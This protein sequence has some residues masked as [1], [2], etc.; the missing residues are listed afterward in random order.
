[1]SKVRSV[2][3]CAHSYNSCNVEGTS[4]TTVINF[5]SV[6]DDFGELSNF[7]AYPIVIGGK[8]FPT[9]EHY[10]QAQK[11]RDVAYQEKIRKASSPMRAANL[12]R[13]RKVK[14]RADWESVKVAVMRT[15][16]RAKFDQHEN[17]QTLL[18]STGDAKLVEH[19]ERD[20]YWGD[21]GDGRGKNMLGRIL[22]EVRSELRAKTSPAPKRL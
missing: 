5:Y 14:L 8:V 12:G 22:M 18:L 1:M 20:D 19:T 17:L 3:R 11:F 7:A 13:D 2:F 16:V 9:S 21:G 10:F 4:V 6:N 15:A